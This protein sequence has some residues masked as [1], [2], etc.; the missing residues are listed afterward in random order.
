[1]KLGHNLVHELGIIMQVDQRMYL[2]LYSTERKFNCVVF[3]CIEFA[4]GSNI[5]T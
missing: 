1:M 2:Q 3:F 5:N 4:I